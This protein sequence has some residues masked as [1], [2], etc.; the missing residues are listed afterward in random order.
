MW[1]KIKKNLQKRIKLIEIIIA[2]I[3]IG[4]MSVLVI[5]YVT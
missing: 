5:K 4:L 1:N 3:I 2:V